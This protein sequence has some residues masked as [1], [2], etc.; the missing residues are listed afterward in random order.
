[1]PHKQTASQNIAQKIYNQIIQRQYKPGERLPTER[2]LAEIYA[3][4]RIPVREAL[5][6]LQ[7]QGVIET[8]HGSGNY[9]TQVDAGKL[10]EQI[11][12]Y[13]MLCDT[14]LRNLYSFWQILESYAA[15]AAA[16][17]RTEAQMAVI[18]RLADDC[19][20]EIR[21]AEA[22][23]P[24]AFTEADAA[25]HSAI[26]LASDNKI[27][28]NIVRIFHQSMRF[29]QD[30]L[31]DKTA[32]IVRLLGIHE[33]MVKGIEQKDPEKATLALQEDLRLGN[34]LFS[35]LSRE[36]KIS[37]LFGRTPA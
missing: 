26:A 29:R 27:I 5:R 16:Q 35:E 17:Q 13:L 20:A 12:Q 1:M 4:S 10:T 15:G 34:T 24:H 28:G 9:V 37:E 25:L 22:G 32:D 31:E 36:Y 30:L 11:A 21:S 23:Q 6:T 19:A 8:K 14:D 3:V 33:S 18:R 2:A 7:Q